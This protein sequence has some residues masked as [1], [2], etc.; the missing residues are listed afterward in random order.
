MAALSEII[1]W[2]EVR[3]GVRMWSVEREK[4]LRTVHP[5]VEHEDCLA[6]QGSSG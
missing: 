6:V 5:L 2:Q 4:A 1:L 3:R